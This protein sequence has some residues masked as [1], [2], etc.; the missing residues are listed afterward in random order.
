LANDGAST[1]ARLTSALSALREIPE[2]IQWHEG[3]LLSPQHFQQQAARWDG[4]LQSALLTQNPFAWG[5]RDLRLDLSVLPAGRFRVR[6]LEAVFPDGSS[7]WY[8]ATAGATA[9]LELD[10]AAAAAAFPSPALMIYLT[11]PVRTPASAHGEA[12]RFI[13]HPG[14]AVVD[15]NTGEGAVAVPRLRPRLGLM[16]G[17]LPPARLCAV[18]I[19][20]VEQRD[21][22]FALTD[23]LPPT[24]T[25]APDSALHQ[26]CA[27]VAQR[28]RA[29]ALFL[30]ERARAP[31][32]AALTPVV[33]ESKRQI[34][35]L[36]AALPPFEALLAGGQPH[37]WTLYLAFCALAGHVAA[38]ADS[39]QPPLLPPY[40][41]DDM[42]TA[43]TA[44]RDF[45][46]RAVSEGISDAYLAIPMELRNG[47]FSQRC[48][49]AWTARRLV[50]GIRRPAGASEADM[51]HWGQQCLAA[52]E[53]VI[54]S[55]REKRIL[56]LRR[57]LLS[58]GD[59]LAAGAGE[60]LFELSPDP[61]F[62]LPDRVL[63]VLNLGGGTAGPAAIMLYVRTPEA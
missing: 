45:V 61:A 53:E 46:L 8:D 57:Q 12:A 17:D 54:P 23:Y 42:R 33:W 47:I 24:V 27:A 60:V 1:A 11:V 22:A 51:V 31:S 56:G 48:D 19:A 3:M 5:L 25:V 20:Q 50:I 26:L 21:D 59:E 55:L 10:L 40:R 58:P 13:S 52:T 18:P 6:Q 49:A 32:V 39:L 34:H 14:E 16:A 44:V 2:A 9:P 62:L 41:H 63:Q 35:S 37:P 4:L 30:A 28:L 36:V 15:E 7:A 38:L 43:F 29:K